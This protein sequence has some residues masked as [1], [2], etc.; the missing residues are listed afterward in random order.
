M[1]G[2]DGGMLKWSALLGVLAMSIICGP[3]AG[4][5]PAEED[6][7]L[8][9]VCFGDSITGDRP[10]KDYRGQYLKWTDLLQFML[11]GR[12]GPGRAIVVNSGW[13]G[14]KTTPKPNEGW[15]G[16]V[17]RVQKDILAHK[18]RIAVILFGGN[19]DFQTDEQQATTRAN[20]AQIAGTVRSAGIHVLMLQY[21][22]PLTAP[23]NEA[24]GWKQL[25]GKNPLI[26]E[27]AAKCGVPVLDMNAP[28]VEAAKQYPSV[29]LANAEDGV[30]LNLRG[31]VVYAR[32]VLAKLDQLGWLK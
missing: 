12:L 14:D 3:G 32:A 24:K 27:V 19:D 31:E 5:A 25:A 21:H 18:P 11:E 23:G 10:G 22:R 2:V 28:M 29:E 1:A 26:A 8:T 15:P 20:L 6:K 16:G 30:H 13:A 9:V 17:G 7:P 4:Q